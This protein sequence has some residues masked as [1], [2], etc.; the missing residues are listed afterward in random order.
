VIPVHVAEKN[1]RRER[2]LF[3][4]FLAEQTQT[5]AAVEYDERF[6][7]TQLDTACIAADFDGSRAGGRDAAANPPKRDLHRHRADPNFGR[8]REGRQHVAK[9]GYGSFVD[10]GF[11]TGDRGLSG[12]RALVVLGCRTSAHRS[13]AAAQT[14]HASSARF[15]CVV[16]SGGRAWAEQNGG[17]RIVE[18]DL[19][20]RTLIDH[21]VPIELVVRERCSHSTRENARYSAQL[22]AR[23]GIRKVTLVTSE[24]HVPRARRHFENEGLDVE[25][26]PVR[27]ASPSLFFRVYLR[28][29][30]QVASV[31][32]RLVR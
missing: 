15:S 3:Q 13:E 19:M 2:H 16:A 14:F 10:G 12:D 18:A 32:D 29:H 25:S 23:R 5:R 27:V 20:A 24:W 30:E 9:V 11:M 6:S 4:K 22:L 28:G 26:F 21:G 7:G 31:L 1:V 17:N 8:H